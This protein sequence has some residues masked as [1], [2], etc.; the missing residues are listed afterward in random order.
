MNP[1]VN[2]NKSTM[3]LSNVIYLPYITSTVCLG[4]SPPCISYAYMFGKR[5]KWSEGDCQHLSLS[6]ETFRELEQNGEISGVE[7]SIFVQ[8]KHCQLF[9]T[10]LC[11]LQGFY[12]QRN[13]PTCDG[14]PAP[15]QAVKV[16]MKN[17]QVIPWRYGH[18]W[19]L[20]VGFRSRAS[21][22]SMKVNT[23]KFLQEISCAHKSRAAA[24]WY[25]RG[26]E[27]WI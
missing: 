20:D 11:D 5:R 3:V 13:N 17:S 15:D 10:I 6:R 7:I 19:L 8:Q 2:S 23:L 1:L 22:V 25:F 21:E 9:E 26:W 12:L 27:K 16:I 14:R 24:S 4:N 18:E